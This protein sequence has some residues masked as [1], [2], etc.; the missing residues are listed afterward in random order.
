MEEGDKGEG[1]ER[2]EKKR[3]GVE[4]GHDHVDQKREGN[5]ER[6]DKEGGGEDPEQESEEGVSSPFYSVSHSWMWPDDW[7]MEHI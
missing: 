6:R 4:A 5:G 2:E 1:R 7:G 3:K